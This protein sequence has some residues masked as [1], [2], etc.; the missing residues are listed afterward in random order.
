M[1]GF[2]NSDHIGDQIIRRSRTGFFI[3]LNNSPIYWL[4]KR[5][6]GI[7][8]S[9][10]GSEFMALNHCCKYVRGLQYKLRMMGIHV[11]DLGPT[12]IFGDN[13]AV[14]VNSSVLDSILKK[15]SNST[16]YR[17]VREGTASDE[18]RT[19]YIWSEDKV[20]DILTKPLGA[21][22][23]QRFLGIILHHLS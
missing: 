11:D 18:Y 14:S 21:N 9:S 17:F 7:E 13:K 20:V 15:K 5:Q 6:P 16:A 23:R 4:S 3:K 8:T 1:I 2:V 10:F 19:A 12:Y 22:K